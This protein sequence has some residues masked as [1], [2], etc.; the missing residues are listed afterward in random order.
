[1]KINFKNA[2]ETL[3]QKARQIKID[4]KEAEIAKYASV[5][6]VR[7]TSAYQTLYDA[8]EILANYAKANNVKVVFESFPPSDKIKKS[9]DLIKVTVSGLR[10]NQ[11]NLVSTSETPN[12]VQRKRSILLQGKDG[13]NYVYSSVESHEDTFL[14]RI[15]RAVENMTRFA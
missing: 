2:A 3:I 1:M 8:R 6:G 4:K 11:V 5:E 13:L 9:D 15:Y 12:I 14:R 10:G 7:Q